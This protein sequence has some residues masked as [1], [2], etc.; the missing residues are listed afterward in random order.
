MLIADVK[1]FLKNTL[2][3]TPYAFPASFRIW[4]TPA[5]TYDVSTNLC[6]VLG[7]SYQKPPVIFGKIFTLP[8]LQLPPYLMTVEYANGYLN[9]TFQV[10]HR[11]QVIAAILAPHH[12]YGKVDLGKQQ[13][14]NY[15]WISA[16]P[17]GYLHVGHARNAVL[18]M[19][20]A[21]ILEFV[22]YNVTREF[23][24]NDRGKQ[25]F[26]LGK[27]IYYAYCRLLNQPL[28]TTDQEIYVNAEIDEAAQ[29]L[30]ARDQ[31]QY[32][33]RDF[34]H[35]SALQTVFMTFGKA[36]FLPK[37]KAIC[38]QLGIK[39]DVW[40]YESDLFKPQQLQRF[41]KKLAAN[42]LIYEKNGATWLK[43]GAIPSDDDCVLIKSSG[44]ATYF[45]GD[46]MY[47]ANKFER[48]FGICIDLW[49]ADHHAHYLKIQK[50]LA[51]LS[52][53]A[54]NYLVNLMQLVKIVRQQKSLKMSKRKGTAYY[55][56]D[57][58]REVGNDFFKFM[59]LASKRTNKFTFDLDL[60]KQKSAQNPLFYCQYAY[61]RAHN[62]LSQTSALFPHLNQTVTRPLTLNSASERKLILTLV[63]FPFYVEKAATH[64]EPY[65]LI[66]YVQKLAKAFH[67]FYE[68]DRIKQIADQNLQQQRLVLTQAFAKVFKQIFTL[69][70][71]STPN[72][73]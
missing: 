16:N 46:L 31:T 69:L 72:R 41:R 24:V 10:Q 71:I 17:T 3:A 4:I 60:V 63:Q 6:M 19:A 49:G 30:I 33:Q 62:V 32:L 14:L 25:I 64:F 7:S 5:N 9:F 61:A 29:A 39:F 18:G 70:G 43:M 26:N 34:F 58:Y 45:F 28:Q 2:A 55:L 56:H 22:N 1:R 73:L 65:F 8:A 11:N 20:I 27:S 51:V 50:A 37:I 47:H 23:Y 38:E 66:E 12:D 67:V 21:N 59:L 44:E 53:P 15:E 40:A 48:G 57:L 36:F 68:N 52:Y 54:H 35:D 42:Q 13:R